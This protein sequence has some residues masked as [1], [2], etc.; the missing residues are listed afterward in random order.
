MLTKFTLYKVVYSTFV[1]RLDRN[2]RRRGVVL[3][4]DPWDLLLSC[5][6]AITAFLY[7]N[8]C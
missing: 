6:L 5:D 7:Y 4:L 2:P 1:R 8:T 3:G